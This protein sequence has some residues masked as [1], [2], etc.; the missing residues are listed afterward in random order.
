MADDKVQI[1]SLEAGRAACDQV[2]SA[3]QKLD[4]I[5][6]TAASAFSILPQINPDMGSKFISEL[7]QSLDDIYN[8]LNGNI[9]PAGESYFQNDNSEEQETPVT[10]RGGG[11]GT[12]GGGTTSGGS[13]VTPVPEETPDTTPETIPETI[14]ET[15]PEVIPAT[16]QLDKLD[17]TSLEKLELSDLNGVVD[18]VIDLAQMEN[19]KVDELLAD[20]LNSDKIKEMLLSSPYVPQEFKDLITDL[21]SSV[22]RLL[23]DYILKGNSPEIF[24]LNT[25]NLG[26]MYSY[27]EGIAEA[28][29]ISL[30]GLLE[31][32]ENSQLLRDTL[33]QFDNVIDLI[34]GWEL[35]DP[36][37]FQSQLK[38]FYLGDVS[39]EFP[40]EDIAAT[41]AYV[42]Y[43]S[44]ECD[45]YYEDFLNDT[46]Y[47]ETLKEGAIQFGK[48][49]TFFKT[50]SFFSDEGMQSNINSLYDGTNYKAF[51]MDEEE[52]TAFK[53]EMD[54]V[55]SEN[56][57][58]VDKLLS[59]SQYA[60]VVK[61]ALQKSTSAKGVG[62]IYKKSDST[63]SQTVA[64]NLYNTSYE[65]SPQQKELDE[66]A[67]KA[68][69]AEKAATTEETS[70]SGEVK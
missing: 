9:Y 15:T 61:D 34:K 7:T 10:P 33:S 4:V 22:V 48:S 50:T 65:P 14:P 24:D 47:A 25:L 6:S 28:N 20:D 37:D 3:A 27:L 63:V 45:V 67:K 70:N 60:D 31:K 17:T 32:P 35:L 39:E 23:L 1:N 8:F 26:I 16:T 13:S 38:D 57:T 5:R 68:A 30:K 59:E 41:R 11:G 49:L 62:S 66:L 19:K 2:K 46:S 52:V 53:S 36:E 40:S 18:D 54:S 69:E 44:E 55:A 29:N 64:K 42:D 51:G 12:S 21:D 58:T 43:L 56:N